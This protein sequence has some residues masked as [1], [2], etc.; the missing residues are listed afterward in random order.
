MGEWTSNNPQ[1]QKDERNREMYRDAGPRHEVENS[2]VDRDNCLE[3]T[4]KV[5]LKG[6]YRCVKDINISCVLC[7][8]GCFQLEMRECMLLWFATFNSELS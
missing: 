1:P 3:L 8:F 7:K 5:T 6:D 2:T 4:I